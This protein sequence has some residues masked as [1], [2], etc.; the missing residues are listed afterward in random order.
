M[1]HRS[2]SG[3][4]QRRRGQKKQT[5][6]RK[7]HHP[8]AQA[9]KQSLSDVESDEEEA[10]PP[11]P[12]SVFL[13]S[14]TDDEILQVVHHALRG[15]VDSANFAV[16]VQKVKSLLYDKQ[17]LEVFCNPA[18]LEAYAGRWVPSRACCYRD[19]FAS[20][21]GIRRLFTVE[22]SGDDE[23][24][25]EDEGEIES[26][27][28]KDVKVDEQEEE[29]EAGLS[30][31]LVT[32]ILSLGGG[33]SSELLAAAALVK[34]CLEAEPNATASARGKSPARWQWT[35][36]DI[37]SWGSVFDKFQSS[38]AA[39]WEVDDKV[40]DVNFVQGD[41]LKA[42]NGEANEASTSKIPGLDI[43]PLLRDT[44]PA[45]I[46][47]LFTLTEL[48]SQSRVD[49]FSLFRSITANV[50]PGT[51][52]LVADSASDISEFE[53]GSSG[54]KWPVW[55]IL[56]TIL[57]GP[58]SAPPGSSGWFC[59]RKEDSRWHRLPEGVGAGWPVKLEN[60]RYWLRLYRRV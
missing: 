17:W 13:W 10:T 37:G 30:A 28:E 50:K 39:E 53:M 42:P 26:E 57:L 22:R 44:P 8:P 6:T 31:Q 18:L 14:P 4:P 25:D 1:T 48:M 49:T 23:T 29:S 21:S 43:V 41:L 46:T 35:G 9:G 24:D 40:F 34:A 27:T 5:H 47:V 7:L 51:L 59:V 54:R 56:D 58:P 12:A 20:L 2:R 38:I 15:T 52:L 16:T 33:A 55:M 36:I 60:T 11:L 45:L 32:R 19:L 3:G